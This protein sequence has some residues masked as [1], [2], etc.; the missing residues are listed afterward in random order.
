MNSTSWFGSVITLEPR[1]L[2]IEEGIIIDA[3]PDI[4]DQFDEAMF[5]LER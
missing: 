5:V 1:G 4:I 2:E 3:N